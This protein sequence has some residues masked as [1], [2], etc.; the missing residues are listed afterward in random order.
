M[1]RRLNLRRR[2]GENDFSSFVQLTH[3]TPAEIR[4]IEQTGKIPTAVANRMTPDTLRWVNQNYISKLPTA[5]AQIGEKVDEAKFGLEDVE[6]RLEAYRQV[7]E[8]PQTPTAPQTSFPNVNP[9]I[10]AVRVKTHAGLTD[11]QSQNVANLFMQQLGIGALKSKTDV[12]NWI[13][14]ASGT[15]TAGGSVAKLFEDKDFVP[16]KAGAQ[17]D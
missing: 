13:K 15:S 17:P 14:N 3:A 1:A 6:Q 10:V 7:G 4:E 2:L 11:E 9:N 5:K 8:I 12:A 16:L